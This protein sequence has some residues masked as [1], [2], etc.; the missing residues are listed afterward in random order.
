LAEIRIVRIISN[1][2]DYYDTALGY[3]RDP[4]L[5]YH[6]STRTESLRSV[7]MP[8][9]FGFSSVTAWSDR[10]R[11]EAGLWFLAF[12][13]KS[14][15]L[16]VMTRE[17]A[18][19]RTI[20]RHCWFVD[21][22]EQVL[23][24]FPAALGIFQGRRRSRLYR[25]FTRSRASELLSEQLSDTVVHEIH[26]SLGSPIVLLRTAGAGY[27]WSPPAEAVV[28]PV[29]K[30]LEFVRVVDPFAAFQEISMYLGGVLGM[31]EQVHRPIPDD[32]MRDMKGFDE[33]SFKT[34]SP[35]DRKRR[36]W[37]KGSKD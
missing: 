2:H 15:P 19:V 11:V 20:L 3:G 21:D 36:R 33:W 37:T 16:L 9:S 24:E 28:D 10:P 31:P 17:E 25:P 26:R 29:L 6:R 35:G 23:Q 13:G 22:V 32:A 12:C 34:V 8:R 30:D 4:K 27:R 14:Y 5:V 18:E 7:T 1:F